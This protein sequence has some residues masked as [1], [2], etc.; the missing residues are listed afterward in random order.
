[1]LLPRE[2]EGGRREVDNGAVAVLVGRQREEDVGHRLRQL[3][4]LP[5]A[6]LSQLLPEFFPPQPTPP[7]S[8]RKGNKETV[9]P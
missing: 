2:S 9:T 3:C 7:H 1:M 8:V 5:Q 6:L 4:T